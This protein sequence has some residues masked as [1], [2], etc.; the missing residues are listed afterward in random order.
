VRD[1]DLYRRGKQIG[2]AAA[3]EL[4]GAWAAVRRLVADEV[5][6]PSVGQL[7][8]HDV[9]HGV[10]HTGGAPDAHLG[11]HFGQASGAC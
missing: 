1:L 4:F 6:A 2:V 11:G 10:S 7:L 8:R 3:S 9:R 5:G